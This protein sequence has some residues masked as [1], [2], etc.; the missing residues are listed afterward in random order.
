[1]RYLLATALLAAALPAS[2]ELERQQM[3]VI[4]G[5]TE[6][7]VSQLRDKYN[8]AVIWSGRETNNNL[9]TMWGNQD[10]NTFTIVKTSPD[11]RMSCAV[12]AGTPDEK[13]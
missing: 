2:A 5:P 4:C 8:E 10:K 11:G 12:S 7:L 6:E 1:M 9:V 13:I 3:N